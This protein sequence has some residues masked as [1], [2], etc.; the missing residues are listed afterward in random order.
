MSD[1]GSERASHQSGNPFL[2]RHKK[3]LTQLARHISYPNLGF[4]YLQYIC[5]ILQP[6][7]SIHHVCFQSYAVF[8]VQSYY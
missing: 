5:F 7:P 4:Q 2:S 3:I 8:I 1:A 6:L